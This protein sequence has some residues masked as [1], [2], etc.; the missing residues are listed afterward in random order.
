MYGTVC[1]SLKITKKEQDFEKLTSLD[2][3]KNMEKKENIL[4]VS[5]SSR[6]GEARERLEAMEAALWRD[7]GTG[8]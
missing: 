7:S 3:T 5:V 6:D 8:S 2:P 1:S 4:N